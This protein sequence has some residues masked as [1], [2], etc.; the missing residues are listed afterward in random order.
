MRWYI[1]PSIGLGTLLIGY[2]YYLVFHI[3]IPRWKQ[4]V[5]VI[6]RDP[7]IVRQ[8]GKV[9]GEWVQALETVEIWWEARG[10]TI[11]ED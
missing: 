4:Q 7:V 5:R 1:I 6:E 3:V 8:F 10:Q 9:D 2:G 11:G